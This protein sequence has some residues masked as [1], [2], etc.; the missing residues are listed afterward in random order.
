MKY[1]FNEG[2]YSFLQIPLITFVPVRFSPFNSNIQYSCMLTVRWVYSKTEQIRSS[3]QLS[4]HH[5]YYDQDRCS[6]NRIKSINIELP[7]MHLGRVLWALLCLLAVLSGGEATLSKKDKKGKKKKEQVEPISTLVV[8]HPYSASTDLWSTGLLLKWPSC[9]CKTRSSYFYIAC[10]S[11][12]NWEIIVNCA[13]L[14]KCLATC[15]GV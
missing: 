3:S 14:F 4:A 7:K 6:L 5:K 10:W 11:I 1:V 2:W 8:I 15:K 13:W 12:C 9:D